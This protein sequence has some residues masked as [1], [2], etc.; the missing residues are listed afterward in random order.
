LAAAEYLRLNY[1]SSAGLSGKDLLSLYSNA[2]PLLLIFWMSIVADMYLAYRISENKTSKQKIKKVETGELNDDFLLEGLKVMRGKSRNRI[3]IINGYSQ[4]SLVAMENAVLLARRLKHPEVSAAHMLRTIIDDREVLA[5]MSRLEMPMVDLR[6]KLSTLLNKSEEPAYMPKFSVELRTALVEGYASAMELGEENV[7]PVHLL[8]P[9]LESNNQVHELFYTFDVEEKDVVSCVAWFAL[10]SKLSRRYRHFRTMAHLKPGGNMDRAYT[11]QATPLLNSY[12]RDLTNLARRMGLGFCIGRDKEIDQVFNQF[13]SGKAGVLLVGE[14][15]VGK[16]TLVG[17]IAQLMVEEEVPEFLQDKRLVELDISRLISGVNASQAQE[18]LQ[19]LLDEIIRSGNIVI[20]INNIETICGISAGNEQSLDLADVLVNHL[21]QYGIHCVASVT[22][23]NYLKYIENQ[24]IG[25]AFAKLEIDEPDER[26]AIAMLEGRVGYFENLHRV[27]FTYH[28]IEAIVKLSNKFIHYKYMP[29]KGIELIETLALSNGRRK[30]YTVI[31]KEHVAE[32]VSKVT[33]VPMAQVGTEEREGLLNLEARIHEHMIDQEEAVSAVSSALRRARAQLNEG[34]R[35]I[36]S[37]LFLGPTGVGKTELAKAIT[38]VFFGDM[39]YMIR[40]DMSEYQ[41]QSMITKMIGD[42]GKEKGYLTEAVRQNAFSLVLLDEFEKA[43]PDILNLFLQVMD[44]GRLTDGKGRTI[45]FTNCI[46]IATS[47]AGAK[48][49]QDSI[50]ANKTIEE[51]KPTLIDEH[52][53]KLM[54]PELLNR[55][56]GLIVFKPLG[57]PEVIQIAT[58]LFNGIRKQ[59]EEKGI[60]LL[61]TDEGLKYMAHAGFDPK[62]G[63]RPLRRVLQDRVENEIAKK[64]LSGELKRRDTVVVGPEGVL[65][66]NKAG[67]I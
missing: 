18:R 51:I 6:A 37:F 46:V 28:A 26:H 12:G 49:I 8:M 19:V 14:V 22:R 25:Q 33:G 17:G 24:P 27:F 21:Q 40:L 15:G 31:T 61:V 1:D 53:T 7:R 3:D 48:F 54:K 23:E 41:T 34:Q 10:L 44:D 2:S 67:E 58:L 57:E 9:L 38:K 55:F 52:L 63:A 62:F 45:D 64:I 5:L 39:K 56:D 42:A 30:Q 11:A 16:T 20:Y 59:L 66:V 43:H 60:H 47:N 32:A 4:L 50:Q 29:A 36:A 13:R 65:S 35:P